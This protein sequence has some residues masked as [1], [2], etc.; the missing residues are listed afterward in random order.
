MC[1]QQS[2]WSPHF[3][4][5]ID[6]ALVTA[7]E[8]VIAHATTGS[9]TSGKGTNVMS[10]W[11]DWIPATTAGPYRD[12][13][14]QRRPLGLEVPVICPRTS[15]SGGRA[16]LAPSAITGS[17]R[18]LPKAASAFPRRAPCRGIPSGNSEVKEISMFS[19]LIELSRG[20]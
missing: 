11:S 19:G 8:N 7:S 5:I 14:C 3:R 9:I 15:G 20:L 17:K 13:R 6:R 2:D 12:W 1:G 4:C 10:I 18:T 16:R